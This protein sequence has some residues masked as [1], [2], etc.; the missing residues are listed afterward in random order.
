[1][2]LNFKK[3]RKTIKSKPWCFE[4]MCLVDDNRCINVMDMCGKAVEYL[5]E[6][7]DV[8]LKEI[9]DSGNLLPLCLEVFKWYI[10]V[11]HVASAKGGGTS[12]NDT[13][14]RDVYKAL[15]EAWGI[16]PS[17]VAAQDPKLL[18]QMF[19]QSEDNPDGISPGLGVLYGM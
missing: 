2:V 10:D 11:M 17:A 13:R 14:L 16:L 9:S 12:A 4:A 8:T 18:L 1:M 5:F 19:I 6:D 7:S 3:G 15:F